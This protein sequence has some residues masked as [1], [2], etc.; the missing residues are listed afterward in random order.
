MREEKTQASCVSSSSRSFLG[1]SNRSPGHRLNTWSV[2]S[3][4]INSLRSRNPAPVVSCFLCFSLP[5]LKPMKKPVSRSPLSSLNPVYWPLLLLS[6]YVCFTTRPLSVSLSPRV[7]SFFLSL[8]LPLSLSF[9]WLSI[10]W[11][12]KS[13]YLSHRRVSLCI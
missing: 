2:D 1:R 9:R 7:I 6:A 12:R 11:R 4:A 8:S 10:T 5:V 3:D 13:F